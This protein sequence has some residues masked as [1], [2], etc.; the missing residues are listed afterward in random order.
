MT[1]PVTLLGGKVI[2]DQSEAG[3]RSGLDAVLLG[4][5]IDIGPGQTGLEFGCGSGAAMLVAA[6]H[7]PDSRF[8]GFDTDEA[9]LAIAVENITANGWQDRAAVL[10]ADVSNP[11]ALGPV[12]QVFFNPPYYDDPK[13]L[14]APDA[15]KQAAYIGHGVPLQ[16]WIRLAHRV[17]I[18][19]GRMTLIHRAER[20]DD[21]LM[22]L[23][24][25]FGD[26]V[27]KPVAPH[28]DQPAKRVLVSA[29]KGVNGPMKLLPPL[30]LH[31]GS[32]RKYT[33]E[34]ESVLRGSDR[35]VVR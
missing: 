29:R 3:F 19:K 12:H 31:D 35:I 5:S 4:A 23:K 16:D 7:N 24:K 6:F 34:A 2:A 30:V 10:R 33:A 32:D 21:I 9:V 26:V 25:W 20:L 27:V 28:A 11:G 14:V 22:L 1:E 13:K 18:P 15:R 8:Q 17:L